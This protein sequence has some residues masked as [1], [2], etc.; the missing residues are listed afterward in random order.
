[1]EIK[2]FHQIQKY[3]SDHW[4]YVGRK[5]LLEILIKKMPITKGNRILDVGCGTGDNLKLLGEFG[6]TYGVDT[7]PIAI[8][9]CKGKK[10]R[11]I[12]LVKPDSQLPFP[13]HYFKLVTCL[14]V[15][16]HVT[17]DEGLLKEMHR[18]TKSNGKIIIFVPMFPFL[19]SDLDKVSHHLRRYLKAN[20]LLK[21]EQA[22]LKVENLQYFNYLFFPRFSPSVYARRFSPTPSLGESIRSSNLTG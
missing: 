12:S 19:W 10:L 6:Q 20:L 2:R 4:W 17:N 15:L 7:E 9:I 18:V 5:R 13:D 11:N 16:E 3:A 1:M 8:K 21:A 22:G 14:D